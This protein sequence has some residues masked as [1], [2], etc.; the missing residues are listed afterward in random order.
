MTSPTHLHD[1]QNWAVAARLEELAALLEHQRASPFRVEAYRRAAETVREMERPVAALL[2]AEGVAG[3][4]RLPAIG[5]TIARAIRDLLT[6]GRLPM[7]D[8][9]RGQSDAV[10]L[11][12]SVP[13][14]GPK[15]AE[16]LHEDHGIDTLE[17]LEAAAHDGRLSAIPLFG[18]KR[19]LGIREALASRLGRVPRAALTS[20]APPVADIL[21]VDRE[22]RRR[23]AEGSL[24][25]IAPRR[26][27]PRREA[28]LPV[29]HTMHGDRAYTALFSNTARAHALG[30]THD[31]VVIYV[32]GGRGGERQY[33][34]VT[35]NRGPL[36]GKRVVRGREVECAADYR[37]DRNT[38]TRTPSES[39][40]VG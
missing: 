8:R 16:R 14:I 28:W 2:E 39:W 21:A 3:L 9:L 34:V 30:K 6:T 20:E 11:L 15:L 27:N 38:E 10:T 19:L 5:T 12:A 26:F 40:P 32:D 35:V 7:L 13:G 33:T 22:Y 4:E 23:A 25:Q 31:W 29:L 36:Q 24:R 18:E 37:G 1:P 17:D